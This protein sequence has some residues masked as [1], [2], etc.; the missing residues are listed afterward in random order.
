VV[1]LLRVEPTDSRDS[2]PCECCGAN[3]RRVWGFVHGAAGPIAAY[4]VQWA[5]GRVA[6]HGANFDLILGRWGEGTAAADRSLVA[7]EYRLTDTGPAFMVIDAA[8]RPAGGSELVG[9]TLARGEVVGRPLAQEAFRVVDAVLAQDARVAELLG[10]YRM[11]PP[12]R[13]PWWRSLGRGGSA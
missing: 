11:G 5:V 6:G 10:P 4:F 12:P 8:G 2:G 1:E 3:T 13:R 9:R 7:L